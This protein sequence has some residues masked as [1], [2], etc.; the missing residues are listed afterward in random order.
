VVQEIGRLSPFP[1]PNLSVVIAEKTMDA[2]VP[3]TSVRG[4]RKPDCVA[5]A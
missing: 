5:R 3:Q 1:V 4:L 2:R